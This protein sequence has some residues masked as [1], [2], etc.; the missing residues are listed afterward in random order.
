[1]Q[2]Q[3]K[4]RLTGVSPLI[5]AGLMIWSSASNAASLNVLLYHHIS[6]KTPFTTSTSLEDFSSQLDYFAEQGYEIVDLQQAVEQIRSGKP[7]SRKSLAITFDDGFESVCNVAYPELKKRG[8]P[9]T[10]FLSTQPVD[11]NYQGFCNWQQLREMSLNGVTIANHTT[12]HG[13]LVSEALSDQPWL[14]QAKQDISKAQRRIRQEIGTAPMLFAY[15]FGEYN[16][17][18]KQWLSEQGYI[19]FGQQSG[20]IGEGSDW[21]ALP[22]F[23]AA[24]NYV[25]VKS[26]RYKISAL[27]MPADYL[28]LPDP[29]IH[30]SEQKFRVTLHPATEVNL[31]Q[32]SCYFSGKPIEVEWLSDTEFITSPPAFKRSGR[33]RVN[34]TAP[35]KRGFPY[36]WLS[37]QWL[38]VN[39]IQD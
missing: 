29:V 15:P 31:N 19:A 7:L 20:S 33:Y 11:D 10:V 38:V 3:S 5:L 32:L 35:H 16:N 22:R 12:Q 27:P 24:G 1:M 6:D 30:P 2:F 9:F 25:S 4:L 21:Q 39:P 13:H 14:E 23:N 8:L 18:L 26:L 17:Q 36:F 28:S 37:H 34:C